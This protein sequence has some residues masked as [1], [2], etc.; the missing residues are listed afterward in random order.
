MNYMQKPQNKGVFEMRNPTEKMIN[1]VMFIMDWV[2][3][4]EKPN[5]DNYW[6]VS[7]FI[8]EH[9]KQAKI[10]KEDWEQGRC[11]YPIPSKVMF[12]YEERDYKSPYEGQHRYYADDIETYHNGKWISREKNKT[13]VGI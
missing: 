13:Y 9:L 2:V 10:V 12:K 4:V 7:N 1:A 8:G 5:I 3:D 11:S 6:E